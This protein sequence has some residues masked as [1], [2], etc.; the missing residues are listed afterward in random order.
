MWI[1]FIGF[2]ILAS[3]VESTAQ[4]NPGARQVSLS[5]SDVALSN[6]VFSLFSNPAG[7]S[8][9]NWREIGIYYSPAPFGFTEMANGYI[10]YHEPFHFGSVG[11]GVMTYGFDLYRENKI[12]SGFSYNYKNKFFAGAAINFHSVSIKNYGND[13]IFYLNLGG[14]YYLTDYFRLGFS[15]QNVNRASFGKEK[16]NS[17]TIFNS[18]FSIDVVDELSFN[19]ALEKDIRYNYSLRSGIEYNL[20]EYISLRSG[21]SN[22]PSRFSAGIGIHYLYFNLDY[23]FFTH[24]DL[25]LTHQ[26]GIIISFDTDGSRNSKI[27]KYLDKE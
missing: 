23:A 6:D 14:L 20:L 18:G 9:M 16:D 13:N 26:A 11:V 3:C 12:T 7:L 22:E 21:F 27:K 8:Q 5:N 10:S 24:Q 17:P 2:L 1:F 19:M 25:G 4:Y 15:V